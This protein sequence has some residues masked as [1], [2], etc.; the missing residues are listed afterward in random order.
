MGTTR[1]PGGDGVKSLAFGTNTDTM[2][3]SLAVVDKNGTTYVWPL[4]D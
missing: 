2:D 1:D 3:A 4:A